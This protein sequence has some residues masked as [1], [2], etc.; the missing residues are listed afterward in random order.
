MDWDVKDS[1]TLL[2]GEFADSH[3]SSNGAE[4][5]KRLIIMRHGNGDNQEQLEAQ[6]A[7]S[8]DQ[9]LRAFPDLDIHAIL[10]SPVERTVRT[11]NEFY[12]DMYGGI[13]DLNATAVPFEQTD[14]LEEQSAGKI[15]YDGLRA[16]VE[17]LNNDWDT[18]CLV[19]HSTVGAP[20]AKALK[21]QAPDMDLAFT[22]SDYASVLVLDIPVDNWQ[23]VSSA[24]AQIA[25]VINQAETL[26][27]HDVHKATGAYLEGLRNE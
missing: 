9:L 18:V 24:N 22:M 16:E 15:G 26:D 2:G 25:K 27:A 19:T 11:A 21:V 5:F 3:D 20:L 23:D 7:H 12:T 4:K 13:E 14:W 17:H 10:Y 6:V 1:T 8:T